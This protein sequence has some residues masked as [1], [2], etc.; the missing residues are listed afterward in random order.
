MAVLIIVVSPVTYWRYFQRRIGTV[1][2]VVF[3]MM[4]LRHVV[5]GPVVHDASHD[6]EFCVVKTS[7]SLTG[8]LLSWG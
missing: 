7:A 5:S 1:S 4:P 8:G 2:V 3:A 6:A